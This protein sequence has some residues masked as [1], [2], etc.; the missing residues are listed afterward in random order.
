MCGFVAILSNGGKVDPYTLDCMRDR[1]AH[2]GP[3]GARSWIGRTNA[4]EV[5]LGHRRLKVI[6][7]SDAAAQPMFFAEDTYAIVYNGE[8]YNYIEL[9]NELS[10]YGQHFK[11]RSDTE[12][13]LAAYAHWGTDCLEHFNGMFAFALWDARKQELFLARDRFGEKPLFVTALPNGGF[14]CASEMKALFAHPAVEAR[15]N[16]TA[17]AAFAEGRFYEDGAESLFHGIERLPPAHALVLGADATTRRRWRYWTP[18]YVS[19]RDD[20]SDEDTVQRFHDLLERSVDLRLRADVPIGTSLSGGLD[21][22]MLVC[23]IGRLRRSKEILT[24]NA[25]SGR[26]DH[27]PAISEGREIDL[28]AAHAQVNSYSVTPDPYRMVEEISQLHWHQE[29][30][31]LSASIYMQWCVMRLAKEHDTIVLIDGQG[32][33]ELLAGYQFYFRSFQLDLIDRREFW[34]LI[35]E[36]RSFTKRLQRASRAHPESSRRF[37]ANIAYPLRALGAFLA[38]PPS[39]YGMSYEEGVAPLQRGM[40][41]RR[42]MSEALLYNSLP[43]LLRYADRNGMA[44]SREPRLPYLDHEL[45]DFC[46][47]LPDRALIQRGWQKH[48]LRKAGEGLLPPTIQWRADKVGYAA[49]LDAWLRGPVKEWAFERLFSGAATDVD[50]YD[51][52]TVRSLWDDHQAGH[53]DNSWALWRWLSLGE[54]FSL[55]E[56]GAWTK[57][58]ESEDRRGEPTAVASTRAQT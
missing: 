12:V 19:I 45:V 52:E 53:A 50:G 14:A 27:D 11:T 26:Y 17:V 1:L 10:G 21:S 44:F 46:V 31:F 2:R 15:L 41:L 35:R 48:V 22:S 33:D 4:G 36:T 5:G 58:G 29:E 30:P 42:Q 37:N 8:I 16:A 55:L 40:R 57:R 24:Q 18:D 47:G 20:L 56:S 9:R 3:D 51:H 13:I 23:M 7:L 49:P 54:W 34:R 28:V 43:M 25:F 6:D 39:V 38:H 32:A